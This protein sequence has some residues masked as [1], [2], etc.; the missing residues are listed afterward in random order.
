M[1]ERIPF[2]RQ[3]TTR[4][5]IAGRFDDLHP[6]FDKQAAVSEANR[7][8]YCFDAPCTT[9][10][11]THIDVPQFIKKIR[12]RMAPWGVNLPLFDHPKLGKV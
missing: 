3:V 12:A 4:P 2:H 10:C 9:A 6:P 8:L 1:S 11:P 5:E 7:C